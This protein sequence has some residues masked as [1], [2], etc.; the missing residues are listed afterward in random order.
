MPPVN[1]L[2][3]EE[4]VPH[5]KCLCCGSFRKML[6]VKHVEVE[7]EMPYCLKCLCWCIFKSDA[8]QV[9]L[10]EAKAGIPHLKYLGAALIL[11]PQVEILV[12]KAELSHSFEMSS[13]AALN[14][15]PHVMH[16][17]AEVKVPFLKLL[18]WGSLKY[19]ASISI[20]HILEAASIYLN[21]P[22][23]IYLTE[24]I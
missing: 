15:L 9:G 10:F 16:L 12:A 4:K 11:M 14:L 23:I 17:K 18:G 6:Q 20:S 8:P 2:E 1:Y 24:S 13:S 22:L 5:L 21:Y 7:E 19:Y 3:T